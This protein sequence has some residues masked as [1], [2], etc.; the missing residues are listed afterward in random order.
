MQTRH[1]QE[2][3]ELDRSFQTFE[4]IKCLQKIWKVVRKIFTLAGATK[5][6]SMSIFF[7]KGTK[8]GFKGNKMNLPTDAVPKRVAWWL[9]L[10]SSDHKSYKNR[11]LLL[12]IALMPE[13]RKQKE[14]EGSYWKKSLTKEAICE[15]RLKYFGTFQALFPRI[16]KDIVHRKIGQDSCKSLKMWQLPKS[17]GTT[18]SKVSI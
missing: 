10:G 18:W 9:L 13:K 5:V 17:R 16:K 14:A 2:K 4:C 8:T 11:L 15:L 3:A 7:S 6:Y 12:W 1:S